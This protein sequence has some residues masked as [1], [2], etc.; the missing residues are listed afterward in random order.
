MVTGLLAA[1]VG[2]AAGI[3]PAW[4]AGRLAVLDAVGG[5]S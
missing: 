3:V 2:A 5:R 4:Q 1:A